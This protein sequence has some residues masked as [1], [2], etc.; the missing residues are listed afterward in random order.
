M[1]VVGFVYGDHVWSVRCRGRRPRRRRSGVGVDLAGA[2]RTHDFD[3]IPSLELL[4]EARVDAVQRGP[5]RDYA[6][7]AF[8]AL[9]A[10]AV[11]SKRR[12]GRRNGVVGRRRSRG[13]DGGSRGAEW[14]RRVSSWSLRASEG[15]VGLRGR[16]M[17]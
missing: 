3:R 11:D 10:S 1:C 9:A 7:G 16:S 6:A 12:A 13:G 2:A 8:D 4:Q 17:S 5:A 15:R 14:Q